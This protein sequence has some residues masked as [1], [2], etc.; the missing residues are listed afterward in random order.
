MEAMLEAMQQLHKLYRKS[1]AR[2][3]GVTSNKI[4]IITRIYIQSTQIVCAK[5]ELIKP[6]RRNK[7]VEATE[8]DKLVGSMFMEQIE[9]NNDIKILEGPFRKLLD[10]ELHKVMITWKLK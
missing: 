10:I 3:T 1:V 2:T 5:G 6:K 8:N 4:D 7:I 9:K